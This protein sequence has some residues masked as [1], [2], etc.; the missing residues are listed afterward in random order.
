MV[1][2]NIRTLYKP[3]EATDLV[4][5]VEKYKMKCV[6]LQE[7]KWDDYGTTKVS[8]TTFFSDKSEENH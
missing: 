5:E 4:M 1:T 7:M 8:K 6:A 2:W 3:G